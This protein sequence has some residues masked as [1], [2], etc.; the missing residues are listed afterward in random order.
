MKLVPY[1]FFTLIISMQ[2]I[3]EKNEILLESFSPDDHLSWRI[4]NDG[5]MGGLSNS[6]MDILSEGVGR[7][8]GQVSLENNGGFASTRALVGNFDLSDTEKIILRVKGD[9][10]RYSFRIRTD[11]YFD[12]L[13]Y[14]ANFDTVENEWQTIEFN[15]SDFVPT[16]RGRRMRAPQLTGNDIRQ[17]GFLIS[18]KQQ[19]SFEILVDWIKAQ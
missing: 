13:S 2:P 6:K 7:F 18:D 15:Y 12:G 11:Q 3:T 1:I 8:S 14:A 17:I 5:V 16:F 10:K 9:G 19:G 4:I